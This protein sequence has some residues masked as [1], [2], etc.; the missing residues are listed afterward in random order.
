MPHLRLLP[1]LR[2]AY[3]KLTEKLPAGI[4]GF[5]DFYL[6]PHLKSEIKPFNGQRARK[7]MFSEMLKA[8]PFNAIVETGT[9][10]GATTEFLA[11]QVQIPLYTVELMPRYFYYARFRC[12][13][14]RNA[15]I[16]LGDSR[17][18]LKGL[19]SGVSF[20]RSGILF[21][22]DAHWYK[23]L[24][25]RDEVDLI[26]G[27][28]KESVVVIDD[29]Q[30]PDDSGCK[31]DDYGPGQRLCLEYLGSRTRDFDIFRP[32]APSSAEEMDNPRGCVVLATKDSMAER[33]RRIKSL[34]QCH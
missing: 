12:R 24:P 3:L 13:P 14:Y 5:L 23:E 21:Y 34:R 20:P 2:Q 26:E 10:L 15:R 8:G 7:E 9:Y 32:S 31:F 30:V 11:R 19:Q 16:F 22:L 29:F 17:Y 6:R 4:A 25:L 33:L 27:G 28:W 18:F 1:L